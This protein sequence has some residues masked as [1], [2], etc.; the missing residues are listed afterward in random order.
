MGLSTVLV[1]VGGGLMA[2]AVFL[3]TG[4]VGVATAY[5]ASTLLTAHFFSTLFVSMCLGLGWQSR[6]GQRSD[7][8]AVLVG[9]FSSGGLSGS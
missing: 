1:F 2:L 6:P 4:L 5:L 9:G 8:S 7:R 3:N